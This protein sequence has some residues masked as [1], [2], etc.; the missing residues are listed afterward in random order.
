MDEH[1]ARLSVLRDAIYRYG[2]DALLG[3]GRRNRE[4]GVRLPVACLICAEDGP[5]FS[6]CLSILFGATQ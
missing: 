5:R 6:D 4:L 3:D 2:F 1:V